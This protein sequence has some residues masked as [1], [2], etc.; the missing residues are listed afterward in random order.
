MIG[1]FDWCLK[2]TPD[3]RYRCDARHPLWNIL[4]A[5]RGNGR[6]LPLI[7]DFDVA[8]MVVGRHAWLTD[9]FPRSFAGARSEIEVEVIAQLQRARSLFTRRDLDGARSAFTARK[10]KAFEALAAAGLDAQGEALAREYL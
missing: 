9:A 8:G 1:N 2:M 3:D 5:D 7:Y 10:Q 6:A 4:A